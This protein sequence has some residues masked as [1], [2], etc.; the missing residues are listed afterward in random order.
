MAEKDNVSPVPNK[1]GRPPKK[2]ASE[3]NT[4]QTN[5]D[6]T[7]S[8]EYGSYHGRV[9]LSNYYFGLNIFDYCS[10]EQLAELVKDPMANNEFLR[11]LSLVL[12]GTNGTFSNSV[13]YMVAMPT[14]DRVVVPYGRSEKKKKKNR[15]LMESTLDTIK[16]K[17]F[18]RDALFR[19][20]VEGTAFYYFET[21]TRPLNNQK[22]LS[23]YEVETIYEI[24]DLGINASVISLPADYTKIVGKKN[25]N[26]VI[27]FNLDYFNFSTGESV[28]NKLRKYPKEIR[29]AYNAKNKNS[30]QNRKGNWVVLDSNKTIVCKIKSK[31]DEPWGRPLVIAAITD[32]L[33]G[34]Y[35]TQTKRNVLD[36]INNRIIYQTFPEGKDKGTSAL[37]KTQQ[38]RQ[39]DAVKSAV[40]NKNNLGG[41]SFFSVAAGTKIDAIQAANTDIFDS[42]YESNLNDKI[43]L[44]IGLAGGLLN[45]VGSGSYSAQHENLQ[46]VS[47]QIFQY[48]ES[49]E[50]ELNK[51]INKNIVKDS[52]NKV[53]VN[54]LRITHVN[55]TD[56]VAYAK[57][58]YL[59]GKGSLSLWAAAVGIKPDV[60]FALLD[61]ELEDDIENKYPVHMTSFTYNG[62]NGDNKGGRPVE[63]DST[64][65]TTITTR[66]NGSNDA[67][68]PSTD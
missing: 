47:A 56:M 26:Y 21:N 49:I 46:L 45:G 7:E 10:P 6:N 57:E 5:K 30:N 16:D 8:Y 14:L 31:Q 12:Y 54:Y 25:S 32:I 63:K 9:A 38:Q 13:D 55:K 39:H 15:A 2:K 41:T 11:K 60:F 1:R 29:D 17:E 22:F 61:Q 67:P 64:V 24:N 27:A 3:T 34:D 36:E 52:S 53:S 33:Y 51:V 44:D 18:V 42:K 4:V 19:M 59:Q 23:D 50:Y 68:K 28:E 43:S 40:L 35:F 65:E 66:A 62:N 37:T 20:M 48:L 58:L